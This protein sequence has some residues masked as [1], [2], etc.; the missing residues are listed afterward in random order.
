MG[1]ADVSNADAFRAALEEANFASTRGDFVFGP[2][3]HP[4]QD[5]Y[6]REVVQEDGVIT[7][8]I[9]AT[10]LEDHADAYAAECSL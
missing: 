4:I 2:N 7:N 8:R 5:I 10:A 6:V 3:H 1:T 9:V